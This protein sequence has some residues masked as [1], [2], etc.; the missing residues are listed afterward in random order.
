MLMQEAKGELGEG[1]PNVMRSDSLAMEGGA[2]EVAVEGGNGG[3]V[4]S[5]ELV[6]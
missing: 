1:R 6:S 3:E 5:V 4:A 2:V